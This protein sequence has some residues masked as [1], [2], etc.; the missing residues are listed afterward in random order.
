[1]ADTLADLYTKSAERFGHDEECA[2]AMRFQAQRD[3]PVDGAALAREQLEWFASW[4]RAADSPTRTAESAA[5]ARHCDSAAAAASTACSWEN[6]LRGI[7][8]TPF[9]PCCALEAALFAS[10]CAY[11][12]SPDRLQMVVGFRTN[13]AVMHT[14][15]LALIPGTVTRDARPH[16]D[17]I[18]A[19]GET[20][21]YKAW[22]STGFVERARNTEKHD[23]RV[24]ETPAMCAMLVAQP[25]P[26]SQLLSRMWTFRWNPVP[27]MDLDVVTVGH[28]RRL[29]CLVYLTNKMI[30]VGI[31][32]G[33]IANVGPH[34]AIMLEGSPRDLERFAM[35][36]RQVAIWRACTAFSG[37]L[38]ADRAIGWLAGLDLAVSAADYEYVHELFAASRGTA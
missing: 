22:S 38:S 32:H 1:M 18:V 29:Q 11:S 26:T 35:M 37:P 36:C 20:C 14:L 9:A 23:G 24:I 10:T 6:L 7:R 30:K 25:A 17:G 16:N 34:D 27:T 19:G 28:I 15:G 8:V 13:N 21:P 4:F 5:I 2:M 31:L 3:G 12:W 33:L